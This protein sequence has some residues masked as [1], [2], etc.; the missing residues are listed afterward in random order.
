MLCSLFCWKLFS[1][2]L[3]IQFVTLLSIFLNCYNIN[4]LCNLNKYFVK[5]VTSMSDDNPRITTLSPL[6]ICS[7]TG[8][9]VLAKAFASL[10]TVPLEAR[11]SE[12]DVYIISFFFGCPYLKKDPTSN[13]GN[14]L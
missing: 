9:Y 14:L 6:V 4:Y 1:K 11:D 8:C 12:R 3:T 5:H 10:L 2:R 7:T 13:A